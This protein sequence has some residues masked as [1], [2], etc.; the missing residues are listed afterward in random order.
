MMIFVRTDGD[1]V[2][3]A[4]SIRAAITR[5]APLDPVYD[6]KPMSERVG[7]ATSQARFSALLLA[8]FAGAALA[9]AAIG[10]YGV[11]S[12]N[13]AQRTHE[14]GIRM[15]L[16]ADAS[17]VLWL[18]IRE[19]AGMAVVGVLIG[20]AVALGA[21]RVLRTLLFDVAPTDLVTYASIIVVVS[22]TAL[23]ASW[24]PARSAARIAP[25]I[26]FRQG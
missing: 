25:S 24:L 26:A 17:S 19:G 1:P 8:L 5:F 18:V 20:I 13:V 7:A 15:A 11:I 10:I 14:I 3:V 22:T 2:A 4:P 9:L 6:I 12:F 23:I 21:T 16:G